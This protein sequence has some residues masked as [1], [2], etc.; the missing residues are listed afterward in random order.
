[1]R[2]PF[3]PVIN[4]VSR[5]APEKMSP[6]SMCFS[7][8]PSVKRQTGELVSTVGDTQL[9]N[10]LECRASAMRGQPTSRAAVILIQAPEILDPLNLCDTTSTGPLRRNGRKEWELRLA[11]RTDAF[12]APS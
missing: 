12:G 2:L 1:M 11:K 9:T 7:F 10:A 6:N 8:A 5:G 3:E 4:S